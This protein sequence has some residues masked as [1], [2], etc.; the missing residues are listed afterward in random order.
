MEQWG[1]FSIQKQLLDRNLQRFRGGLVFKARRLLCHA[2]LGLRVIKKEKKKSLRIRGGWGVSGQPLSSKHGTYETVKVFGVM[3][4]P[5]RTICFFS[6]SG[7]CS[8]WPANSQFKN[9]CLTGMCS[10]SEAGLQSRL[11][12]FCVIQL[13][14][15]ESFFLSGLP[16][17]RGVG[18]FRAAA[19]G[20]TWYI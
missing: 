3:R 7:S 18:R 2:T 14:R 4:L 19:V 20:R 10:G 1:Q 12:D 6:P 13:S 9:N 15:L 16:I 5:R 11:A 17:R 8:K